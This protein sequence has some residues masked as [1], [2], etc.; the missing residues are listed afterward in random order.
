MTSCWNGCFTY[1]FKHSVTKWHT[2]PPPPP[3]CVTTFMNAPLP[4]WILFVWKLICF[5]GQVQNLWPQSLAVAP[6]FSKFQLQPINTTP[7]NKNIFC[8]DDCALVVL[9][10]LSR[11]YKSVPKEQWKWKGLCEMFGARI[12]IMRVEQLVRLDLKK[13]L[14]NELLA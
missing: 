10:C 5:L 14:W 3:N 7:T 8:N 13:Y 12:K 2:P 4:V 11:H 1:T 9:L 6:S